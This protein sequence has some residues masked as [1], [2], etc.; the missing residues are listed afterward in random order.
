MSS[1]HVAGIQTGTDFSKK[2]ARIQDKRRKEA[3]DMVDKYGVGETVHRDRESGK[4]VDGATAAFAD[5]EKRQPKQQQKVLSAE[6]QRLLNT[7]RAQ[8]E[9]QEQQTR[10]FAALRESSFARHEDDSELE[11]IRKNEIRADDPMADKQRKTSAAQQQHQRPIYKG[12]PPK[13]NRFGIPPGHRWDAKDRGNGFEDKLL[14]KRFSS[15][16]Q[17]EKAYRYSA[18]DM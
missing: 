5:S 6:E 3:Q 15:Q 10:E 7:G 1:G 2:E 13:P 9:R 16:H 18:A 4:K 8:L 12:P 17:K 11:A 14:A